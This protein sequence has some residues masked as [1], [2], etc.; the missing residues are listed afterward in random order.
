MGVLNY[1]PDPKVISL[2]PTSA[3]YGLP[4]GL[5]TLEGYRYGYLIYGCPELLP[6]GFP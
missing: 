4:A 6:A 5:S 3:I 2:P 1:V